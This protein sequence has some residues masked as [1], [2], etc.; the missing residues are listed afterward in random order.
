MTG[1]T[2]CT[3]LLLIFGDDDMLCQ[4]LDIQE[5]LASDPSCG[6]EATGTGEKAAELRL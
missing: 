1:L 2:G 4:V 6:E 5:A 3:G